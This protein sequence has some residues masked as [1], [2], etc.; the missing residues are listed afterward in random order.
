MLWLNGRLLA[1]ETACLNP[2]D[3]G[4]L[5]GDGVF[6]TLR[7]TEHLDRHLARLRNGAAVLGIDVGWTDDEIARGAAAVLAG[8]AAVLRIT[9]SRGPGGR[10]ILPAAGAAATLL[11]TSTNL[12][13]ILPPARVVIARGT[14]RNEHSPLSRIKSLNYLDSIL[15]RQEAALAGADDAILLNTAGRVA[16]AAA[17][18]LFVSLGGKWVTPPVADGALPGIARA[19]LL[20]AGF[21][22]ERRIEEAWLRDATAAFLTSSL[23]SRP[24]ASIDGRAMEE[25]KPGPLF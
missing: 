9:L 17:S 1:S 8:R 3:R 5:L 21:A 4:F 18:N 19:L 25:S 6:E 11:I 10:G 20:E 2:Q 13:E 16:E 12:P 7:G 15:A 23:G 24:I 14:R 22:A